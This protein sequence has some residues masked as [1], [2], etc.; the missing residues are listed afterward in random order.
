MDLVDSYRRSLAVFTD[1][2]RQVKPDQWRGPTACTDWDVH[3]LVNHVV[4]EDRWTVPLFG[5]ATIADVGDR[6]DG[7]LLGDDPVASASDAAKQAEAAV[8]EPGAVDK[9]VHLSFGD[10]PAEEY[11]RQLL[12]D[13]LVHAWDVA[14]AIGADRSLPDDLVRECATWFADREPLYRSGGAIAARVE[15]ADGASEQDRLIAAFGRD[16]AWTPPV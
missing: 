16:P 2:V 7:D 13:H 4:N 12:A 8:A 14:A 6:F 5:G 1:R 10:T 15:V 11:L 9:V 3:A